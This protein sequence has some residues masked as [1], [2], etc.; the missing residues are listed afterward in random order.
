LPDYR[1][2]SHRRS[3][4]PGAERF[5]RSHRGKIA[6]M[7]IDPSQLA[8]PLAH[9]LKAG[10]VDAAGGQK[11]ANAGKVTGGDA[12]TRPVNVAVRFLIKP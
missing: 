3:T 8:E 5:L 7:R 10:A 9:I 4:E 6:A 12:E 11:A 1:E 2:F